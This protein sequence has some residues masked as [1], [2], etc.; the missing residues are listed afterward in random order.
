MSE[1]DILEF[2]YETSL[3]RHF[4]TVVDVF[5]HRITKERMWHVRI[6][7]IS[8]TGGSSMSQFKCLDE[9]DFRGL[10]DRRISAYVEEA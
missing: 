4:V 7:S 2:E 10:A 3:F 9:E 1:L 8:K 5:T 6:D